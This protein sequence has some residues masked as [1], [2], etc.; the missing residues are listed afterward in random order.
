[1]T[2]T[3]PRENPYSELSKAKKA[4]KKEG[5]NRTL[6]VLSPFKAKVDDVEIAADAWQ[7]TKHQRFINKENESE[8][9][10]L[11]ALSSTSGEKA[12]L[13]APYGK[14]ADETVDDFLRNV[15][16]NGQLDG[17]SQ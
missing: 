16:T 3:S 2:L 17:L 14:F 11:Y 9:K 1:M 10:A 8:S 7:I 15:D 12:I 13:E 4:L 6:E 5:F